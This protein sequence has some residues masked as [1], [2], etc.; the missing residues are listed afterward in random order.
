MKYSQSSWKR[1]SLFLTGS[2][3]FL[4]KISVLS[5]ITLAPLSGFAGILISEIMY[6]ALGSDTGRE[7]VEIQNTEPTSVDIAGWKLF[8][9][10]V[11][12]KI[13]AHKG[14]LLSSGEYAVITSNTEKF[15]ADWPAF[16]GL[17]FQSSFSLKNTGEALVIKNASSSVIASVTYSAGKGEGDGNS[18]NF[19]GEAWG[20]RKPSPGS[21]ISD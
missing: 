1:C 6:D 10:G 7:W 3:R 14:T 13:V 4:Y 11:N 2:S 16:P 8:E 17:L 18:L 12:H 5:I 21:A 15:L 19:T 20:A 9:A